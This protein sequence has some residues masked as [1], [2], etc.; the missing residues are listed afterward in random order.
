MTN[1]ETFEQ[2]LRRRKSERTTKEYLYWFNRYTTEKEFSTET[3]KEFYE[4]HP[5]SVVRAMIQNMLKWLE[6]PSLPLETE[7]ENKSFTLPKYYDYRTAN[8]LIESFPEEYRLILIL[9]YECGLRIHEAINLR[10]SNINYDEGRIMVSG[11]GNKERIAYPSPKTLNALKTKP[12]DFKDIYV[13]S[14]PYKENS[15]ISSSLIRKYL[16]RINPEAT[17]HKF[18]HTY[19]TNL[20]RANTPLRTIQKA[21]GHADPKTTSIYTHIMDIDLLEA[22]KKIWY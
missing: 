7:L 17:P 4:E 20:L 13:F 22:N 2:Y 18:R 6:Y 14:S 1:E 15:P 16:K 21:L 8:E 9:M 12:R 10:W 5:N 19:A 11:K 3:M